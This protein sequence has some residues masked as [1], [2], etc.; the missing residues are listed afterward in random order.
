MLRK[1]SMTSTLQTEILSRETSDFLKQIIFLKSFS[2]VF[3][4][5]GYSSMFCSAVTL[6]MD[7]TCVLYSV[8]S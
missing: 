4:V 5:Y 7:I 2:S 8:I 1:Y 3:K 6:Q